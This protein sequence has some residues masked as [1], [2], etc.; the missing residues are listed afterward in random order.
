MN[1]FEKFI[2]FIKFE[3]T[4]TQAPFTPYH[5]VM[6]SLFIAVTVI[7]CIKAKDCTD[8]TFRKIIFI[9]WAVL[10]VFEIYKQLTAPFSVVDGKAKWDYNFNDIPYQFCSSIHYTLLPIVFL[11]DGKVR[12][13]FLSFTMTFVFLA[14]LMVCIFPDQLKGMTSAG[15]ILQTMVHHGLQVVAGAFIA[16]RMRN[17][18]SL[19]FFLLGVITFLVFLVIALIFNIALSPDAIGGKTIN[20]FYISPYH[21]CPLP[22][23]GD[24]RKAV[25]WAVFFIIYFIGFNLLALLIS[26]IF[27]LI[28]KKMQPV[29][30]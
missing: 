22:V 28:T 21:N 20:F 6:L 18:L 29:K 16:I 8:K 1:A 13:A 25:P 7:L 24:I 4:A 12:D 26:F 9:I 23:L 27:R 11:K 10:F 14:G 19:K 30:E 3:T 5:I 17:K 2:A 15:I